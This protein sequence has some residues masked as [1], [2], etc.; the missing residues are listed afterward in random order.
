MVGWPNCHY[1]VSLGSGWFCTVRIAAYRRAKVLTNTHTVH[2][3]RM[4]ILQ[5]HC[6][7]P[8]EVA[9]LVEQTTVR[10]IN[11]PLQCDALLFVPLCPGAVTLPLKGS[12]DASAV[13]QPLWGFP[14]LT[15]QPENHVSVEL[16]VRQ[17]AEL[18]NGQAAAP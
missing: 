17:A 18:S 11:K 14:A 6:A 16:H 13:N 5:P 15:T 9:S 7:A 8:Q 4:I 12:H 2:L 3:T 10:V 1:R